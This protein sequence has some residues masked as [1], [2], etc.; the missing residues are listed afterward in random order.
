MV[1]RNGNVKFVVREGL[2]YRQWKLLGGEED[3]VDQLVLPVQCRRTVLEMAHNI[4]M[5]GH[6]GKK[7]ALFSRV[8]VPEEILPDQ[9]SNFTS[10]LLKE[11]YRMLS[12]GTTD[13]DKSISS[14][15]RW[16]L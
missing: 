1:T 3:V 4:P 7:K 6:L 13:K 11:V 12:E 15:N 14:R 16:T 5:T 8:G 2:L 9:G 10:Q